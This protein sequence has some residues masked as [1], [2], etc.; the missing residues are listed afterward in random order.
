MHLQFLTCHASL[1]CLT[2]MHALC[3]ITPQSGVRSYHH[4][5]QKPLPRVMSEYMHA[6]AELNSAAQRATTMYNEVRPNNYY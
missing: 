4:Y 5:N 2:C 1:L 3:N 6:L